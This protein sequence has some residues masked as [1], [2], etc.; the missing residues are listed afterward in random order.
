MGRRQNR[1]A[2]SRNGGRGLRTSAAPFARRAGSGLEAAPAAQDD[3]SQEQSRGAAPWESIRRDQ[4]A[5]GRRL[6]RDKL[7][8]SKQVVQSIAELLADHLAPKHPPA[9][10]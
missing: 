10:R 8:P 6:V 2:G 7:Y 3:A 1:V 4:V 5:K 9:R